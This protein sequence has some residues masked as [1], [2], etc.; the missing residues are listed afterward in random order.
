MSL[1]TMNLSE[2]LA[3]HL[4]E[5]IIRGDLAPGERLPEADLAKTMSVSTNSLRE[6]FH[7][8]EN[9]HLIEW[10][11]RRGA[12]V[13]DI[14]EQQVRDLYDFLFLLLSQLAGRAAERWQTGEVEDLVNKL[15]E[16][17]RH[18]ENGDIAS[19]HQLVF[20]VVTLAIKRFSH[21]AYL[22][23]DIEDLLPLLKR[24]SYMALQEE[25]TE[26]DQSLLTFQRLMANLINRDA[27]QARADIK[28]YGENQC[29][30]VL[31]ALAKRN[32]A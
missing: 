23:R 3:T 28:E 6:A 15:P 13:C 10:R 11:P 2:Q 26:F 17:E 31:R 22:Q 16:L 21:N 25:T 29:R 14:T 27:D 24:F 20:D 32:A 9:C 8:L 18:Y 5:R 19:A 4:S 12:S 7:I 30:V 1:Q